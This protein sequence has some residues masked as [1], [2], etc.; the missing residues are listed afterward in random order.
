ML[1]EENVD[2]YPW[3]FGVK[4]LSYDPKNTNHKTK[5]IGF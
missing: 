2:S 3:N 5:L 1:T 4:I